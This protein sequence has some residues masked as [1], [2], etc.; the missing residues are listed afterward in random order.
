MLARRGWL[1]ALLNVLQAG[2]GFLYL[3]RRSL[4]AANLV[5]IPIVVVLWMLSMFGFFLSSPL[6]VVAGFAIYLVIAIGV[7]AI[8][9]SLAKPIKASARPFWYEYAAFLAAGVIVGWLTI[10]ITRAVLITDGNS[11]TYR[12]NY[13]PSWVM[14][15]TIAPGDFLVSRTVLPNQTLKRGEVV[16]YAK[17]GTVGLLFTSRVAAVA[18]DTIELNGNELRVNGAPVSVR[19]LCP[20]IT[21]EDGDLGTLLAEGRVS[22]PRHFV[23]FSDARGSGWSQDRIVVPAGHVFLLGDNRANADDSRRFG[24]LPV[25]DVARAPLYVLWSPDWRRITM[26]LTDAVNDDV[27]RR[28]CNE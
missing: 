24:P 18:G 16:M 7:P 21:T 8:V 10:D 28:V 11:L 19:K 23:L 26:S 27:A 1:A 14:W 2:L 5:V 22:E 4:A 17:P 20:A 13:V 12:T 15:P 25:A 3:G 9:W 6:V